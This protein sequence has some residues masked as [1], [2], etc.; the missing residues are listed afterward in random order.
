M[1][2][3]DTRA[4]VDQPGLEQGLRLMESIIGGRWNPAILFVIEQGASRYSD[5]RSS[6]GYISDTELQRKLNVLL[7][8]KLIEKTMQGAEERSAAYR[9]TSFGGEITHTLHHI[10]DISI[11]H[12]QLGHGI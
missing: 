2:M 7:D 5:I 12:Q 3:F 11:K 6:I 1:S 10:M 4:G 8:G 9:L